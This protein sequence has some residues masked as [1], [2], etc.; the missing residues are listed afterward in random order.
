MSIAIIP[1]IPLIHIGTSTHD[2]LPITRVMITTLLPAL[3]DVRASLLDVRFIDITSGV[4]AVSPLLEV[5]TETTGL[6]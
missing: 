1:E 4:D 2:A 3:D 5:L 6:R